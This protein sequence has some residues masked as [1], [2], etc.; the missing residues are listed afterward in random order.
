M[1]SNTDLE[2]SIDG[3]FFCQFFIQSYSLTHFADVHFSE[4]SNTDH[5]IH[6]NSNFWLSFTKLGVIRVE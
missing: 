3:A 1:L 5:E 2:Q 4:S 6:D